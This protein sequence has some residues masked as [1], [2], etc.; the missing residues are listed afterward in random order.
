M[1]GTRPSLR[2][3]GPVD[4]VGLWKA[5]DGFEATA[6]THP[7]TPSHEPLENRQTNAGFPQAPTGRSVRPVHHRQSEEEFDRLNGPAQ[8]GYRRFAP[9]A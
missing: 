9:T 1:T 6:G 3:E 2:S 5:V 7:S 8:N 4:A